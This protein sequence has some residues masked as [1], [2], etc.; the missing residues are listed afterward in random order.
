MNDTKILELLRQSKHSP[1]MDELYEAFPPISRFIKNHGG[2]EDDARDTFQEALIIFCRKAAQADFKLTAKISTYIFSVCKFLWKDKLQKEN[3]YVHSYDFEREA[4]ISDVTEAYEQEQKYQ[5]LDKV[6]LTI[7]D[8]CKEILEA[9][10]V[11]KWSMLV[12][13]EKMG[14]GS[15]ASAKN[16]KYKCLEKARV[17]AKEEQLIFNKLGEV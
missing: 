10:Y 5:F 14:Y 13:A 11:H 7:G 6:L 3:R 9:Y 12:I 8:R 2:S 16:Q 17:L 1:A 4:D 15:E